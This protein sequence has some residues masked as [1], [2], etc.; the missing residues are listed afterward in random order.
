MHLIKSKFNIIIFISFFSHILASYF[1]TGWVNA[2]EQSCVLEYVN[3]KL[4]YQS[5][6]CFLGILDGSV[7]DSSLIIRSWFQPFLYFIIAKILIFLNLT[8]FFT[9]TFVLKLIS[10]ML[11]FYAIYFFYNVT[12]KYI[13]SN[14]IKKFYFIIIF[15]YWFF[16]LLHARTSAEN[17]STSFLLI[18]LSYYLNNENRQNIFKLT[19]FGILLGF[20][21]V[22]RYNVGVCVASILCW[23]LFF[24]KNYLSKKIFNLIF[25]IFG[26]IVLIFIEQL[27]NLWGIE[28]KNFISKI[29]FL[30]I[31]WIISKTPSIQF[32]LYGSGNDF[33]SSS[34][35]SNHP[36]FGYFYLT[37]F[38]YF[39]P[40]SIL[41]IIGLLYTWFFGFRNIIVWVTLPYFII[42]SLIPHKELRYIYPVLVFAPYFICYFLDKT[43][44]KEQ[45]KNIFIKGTLILNFF[46]LIF[47]TFTSQTSELKILKKI[48]YSEV[49]EVYYINS[50]NSV[51]Y[52]ES[53]NPFNVKNISTNYYF[54][55]NRISYYEK[56]N[57]KKTL[58]IDNFCQRSS[59]VKQ[60]HALWKKNNGNIDFDIKLKNIPKKKITVHLIKSENEGEL[61][62]I[63][64]RKKIY[65]NFLVL[66]KDIATSKY[67]SEQNKCQII[68]S[69]YPKW[70][71]SINPKKIKN[72]I[73]FKCNNFK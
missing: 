24:E 16:P 52:Y 47:F 39:P 19:S 66:T 55:F 57:N 30:D 15:L 36:F 56:I 27:T 61:K 58:I 35:W 22:F 6:P 31:N 3:F 44:L 9:I 29:N 8:N 34:D 67:F 33:Y 65:S 42:H 28:G 54:K 1:S 71:Y 25:I 11:G 5:D 26:I 53:L 13:I 14:K 70:V 40:I 72:I 45:I 2:D 68:E 69:K 37:L 32:F 59:C 21:F 60:E 63:L 38:K 73:L 4:G 7:K 48:Y 23:I 64:K 43:N 17:L 41:V 10:S 51:K 18:A 46:G 49:K 62:D 20:A 12:K 50:L